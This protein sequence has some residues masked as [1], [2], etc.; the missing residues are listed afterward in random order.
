M[1]RADGPGRIPRDFQLPHGGGLTLA[2]ALTARPSD[3]RTMAGGAPNR[4]PTP[5]ITPL[6]NPF[7]VA[8]VDEYFASLAFREWFELRDAGETR[9]ALPYP[10]A[11][12]GAYCYPKQYEVDCNRNVAQRA[13]HGARAAVV[14]LA[15]HHDWLRLT[16]DVDST[17]PLSRLQKWSPLPPQD[18]PLQSLALVESGDGELVWLVPCQGTKNLPVGIAGIKNDLCGLM[19]L[20]EWE[21]LGLSQR[22]KNMKNK[23]R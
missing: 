9:I 21:I 13:A 18:V 19:V 7:A 6:V 8:N 14:N 22:M 23:V 2:F 16:R 3:G 11:A 10:R 1:L 12:S 4:G 5:T 20:M 15:W 17:W